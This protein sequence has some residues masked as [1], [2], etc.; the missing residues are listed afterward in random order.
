MGGP[1]LKGRGGDKLSHFLD[2]FV[3]KRRP[4]PDRGRLLWKAG[5]KREEVFEGNGTKNRNR[6]AIVSRSYFICISRLLAGKNGYLMTGKMRSETGHK[7]PRVQPP[8][9]S[10]VKFLPT[11]S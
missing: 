4:W 3:R 1:R 6:D 9:K 2:L 11:A 10:T 8:F 7:F 5:G